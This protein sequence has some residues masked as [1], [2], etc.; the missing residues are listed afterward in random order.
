MDLSKISRNRML[1]QRELMWASE[2]SA[3]TNTV[4]TLDNDVNYRMAM[5]ILANYICLTTV[6]WSYDSDTNKRVINNALAVED[7][8]SVWGVSPSSIET[9]ENWLARGKK[10]SI[11]E[12]SQLMRLFVVV[13]ETIDDNIK[14]DK[15]STL[16]R[17]NPASLRMMLLTSKNYEFIGTDLK[18]F[19][20][21]YSLVTLDQ[22]VNLTHP[23]ETISR[24][25]LLVRKA[26]Q[27]TDYSP[28]GVLKLFKKRSGGAGNGISP[29]GP[30]SRKSIFTIRER[31]LGLKNDD[32]DSKRRIAR[33]LANSSSGTNL[34]SIQPDSLIGAIEWI[35]GLPAGA[36]TSGTTAE[37]VGITQALEDYLPIEEMLA[38]GSGVPLYL[39]PALA[40]VQ[41][42]HHTFFECA[43]AIY[44]GE[45]LAQPDKTLRFVPGF[46]STILLEASTPLAETVKDEL[47]KNDVNQSRYLFKPNSSAWSNPN[48]N[49][50][51][52][53]GG[54]IMNNYTYTLKTALNFKNVPVE[55]L[56]KIG[57]DVLNSAS[58][59]TTSV[60]VINSQMSTIYG[61]ILLAM[62]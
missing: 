39:G 60:E 62:A 53:R 51:S 44:A 19:L 37:V 30:R 6:L 33:L 17:I 10:W 3:A 29:A 20:S 11:S 5:N 26:K 35:Y 34:H 36:D 49:Q 7:G 18:R 14:D 22:T 24:W 16:N 28:N 2:R 48:E 1:A 46:Y 42:T 52:I 31:L 57:G 12:L 54:T 38:L 21:N 27:V 25:N 40:I 8:L 23:D 50:I 4:A 59:G 58:A 13:I 47:E 9:I 45:K 56:I 41:N 43:I 15:L 61:K 32:V 55:Q